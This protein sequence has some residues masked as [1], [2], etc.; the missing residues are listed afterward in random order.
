MIHG[1]TCI[2]LVSEH[3]NFGCNGYMGQ[4]CLC[5]GLMSIIYH[6]RD[7]KATVIEIDG[8]EGCTCEHEVDDHLEDGCWGIQGDCDC[9][10]K[11]KFGNAPAPKRRVGFVP[12]QDVLSQSHHG[13]AA[14]GLEGCS[15]T[16]LTLEHEDGCSHMTGAFKCPCKGRLVQEVNGNVIEKKLYGMSDAKVP[17]CDCESVEEALVCNCD[18][19]VDDKAVEATLDIITQHDTKALVILQTN[20]EREKR[21]KQAAEGKEILGKM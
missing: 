20:L 14:F 7:E 5:P 19:H 4:T 12:L 6:P 8:V 15:C 16:H 18:C 17:C 9:K 21:E 1:C 13:S 11:R 10:G 3:R 2:H